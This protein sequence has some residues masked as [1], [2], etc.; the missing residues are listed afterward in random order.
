MKQNP[1]LPK[2]TPLSMLVT[3]SNLLLNILMTNLP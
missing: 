1:L 3:F 2:I